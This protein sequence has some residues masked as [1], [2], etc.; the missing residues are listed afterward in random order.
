MDFITD[1]PVSN[2][3]DSIWVMVNPFIKMAHFVP[4]EID[5]K[6]TDDLIRLFAWHYWQLHGI[7]QDIISDR[8]F[9]FISRL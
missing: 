5:G 1:L 4:L 8:D 3:C 2:N 7:P 6:K 9:Y